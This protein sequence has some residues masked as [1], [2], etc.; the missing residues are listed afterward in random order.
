MDLKGA[1]K[2]KGE[3]AGETIENVSIIIIIISALMVTIG[4]GIG[5]YVPGIPVVMAMAGSS[6][7]IV[8]IVVFVVSEFV[9]IYEERG[10]E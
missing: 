5:S 9:K 1:F 2:I 7:V 6:L 3:T 4:I 8:G 10:K